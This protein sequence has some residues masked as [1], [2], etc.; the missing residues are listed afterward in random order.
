MNVRKISFRQTKDYILD[1]PVY[2]GP[3]STV[4]TAQ[5]LNPQRKVGIKEVN[6]SQMTREEKAAIKAEIP[7]WCDYAKNSM[8]IPQV[9]NVFE[10]KEKLYIVMQWIDGKSLR[11]RM[12]EGTLTDVEKL[13]IVR[14]LCEALIPIHKAKKQ[15]KDLKPENIM[16]TGNPKGHLRLYLI[17]FNLSAA[18]PHNDTGTKGY[19]PPECIGLS[20][21]N[22][23]NRIDVYAIGAILYELFT[24][25]VP[26]QKYGYKI[27]PEDKKAT[28]YESFTKPSQLN[29]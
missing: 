18:V 26:V 15:H 19:L 21:Q 2:E 23:Y 13:E 1:P 25:R 16:V 20:H 10:E 3:L 12:Q 8:A 7:V 11:V 24:G 27:S 17:D 14:Q 22:A 5:E 28:D 4:Y 6:L 9:L 29:P